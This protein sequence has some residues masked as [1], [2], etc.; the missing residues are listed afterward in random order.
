MDTLAGRLLIYASIGLQ[1]TNVWVNFYSPLY[2]EETFD[3][4][5]KELSR[6]LRG[7]DDKSRK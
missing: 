5:R 6:R 4:L 7:K 1:F 3:Q 2:N